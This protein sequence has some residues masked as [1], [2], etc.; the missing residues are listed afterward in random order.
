VAGNNESIPSYDKSAPSEFA[1]PLPLLDKTDL[2][3][4]EMYDDSNFDGTSTLKRL[5]VQDTYESVAQSLSNAAYFKN[6][7]KTFD[8][9]SQ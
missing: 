4:P 3:S 9:Q 5:K 6:E 7:N 2:N 1:M 8:L